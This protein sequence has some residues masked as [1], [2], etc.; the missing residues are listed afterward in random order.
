MINVHNCDCKI[1]ILGI[2]MK[3]IYLGHGNCAT[4]G[5]FFVVVVVLFCNGMGLGCTIKRM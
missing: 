5:C 1:C 4:L 3:F 2:E